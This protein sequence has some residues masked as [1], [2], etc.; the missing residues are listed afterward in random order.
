MGTKPSANIA[1]ELM[2]EYRN[3]SSKER[4]PYIEIPVVHHL[5]SDFN[6]TP[7]EQL[8]IMWLPCSYKY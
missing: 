2:K 7:S 3:S 8:K 4:S 6:E 1:T 5:K